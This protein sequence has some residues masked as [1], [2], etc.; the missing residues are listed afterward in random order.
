[1]KLE[2]S[3]RPPSK[4]PITDG[5][6]RA[7]GVCFAATCRKIWWQNGRLAHRVEIRGLPEVLRAILTDG[8]G[9]AVNE[10]IFWIKMRL[11]TD[12]FLDRK[13][14]LLSAGQVRRVLSVAMPLA[15]DR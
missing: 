9:K 15:S 14:S 10:S 13:N 6:D 5:K 11:K 1:M 3:N 2:K 12:G 7:C 4:K 8:S